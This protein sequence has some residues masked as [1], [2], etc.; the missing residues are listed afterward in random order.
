MFLQMSANE[1]M[2][3]LDAYLRTIW[4]ECCDHLSSFDWDGT[5]WWDAK[6]GETAIKV[7]DSDSEEK[8]DDDDDEDDENSDPFSFATDVKMSHQLGK[9]AVKIST[10]LRYT[11]DYGDSTSLTVMAVSM[12]KG[13]PTTKNLIA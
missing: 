8:D 10:K 5:S 7:D 11:Y 9:F 2:S 6:K 12:R 4:L 13:S 3:K 1:T